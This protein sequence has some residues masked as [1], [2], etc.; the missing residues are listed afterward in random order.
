MRL[1]LIVA[2]ILAFFLP[3]GL[4]AQPAPHESLSGREIGPYRA[5]RTT[6][7]AG[8]PGNGRVFFIGTVGGGVWRTMDAGRSWE[9]ISDGTFGTASVGAIAIAPSDARRM[10]VGMGES[11]YR[12][13]MSSYGDGIY[14]SDDGGDS[15]RKMGLP[16]VRQIAS[17]AIHSR[18]P[19]IV[20]VAAQGDPWSPT[21]ERGVFLSTDGGTTWTRSLFTGTSA[22][23]AE[24]MFDPAD[25]QTVYAS[26][27][28]HDYDPWFLRSG[29]A[30]SGIF[31]STDSGKSWTRLTNGLPSVSG[32]IG[33]A[34][35]PVD[36]KLL[37]AVIETDLEKSGLYRSEDAGAS[38]Q[39]VNRDRRLHTRSWY[40]M[41]V[42]AD[43][44]SRDGVYSMSNPPTRSTD[45]GKTFS[46][47]EANGWDF[48]AIWLDPK[49]KDVMIVGSDGGGT[50]SVDG[51]KTWSSLSNQPTAQLYRVSVDNAY[52]YNIYAAQQDNTTLM[53]SSDRL[54]GGPNSG[55]YQSVGGG[56]AG[57]ISTHP[58]QNRYVYA[59]S[60]LG[61]L[62]EYDR[63]TGAIRYM[64]ATLRFPEGTQ[65]RDLDI[66]YAVNSPV[67]V[68]WA[69]PN[70][71]Y[72]A[73][74]KVMRTR[75]RGQNWEAI[76]P[77]LTRND[78][79]KQGSGG[80]PFS[81]ELIN[82]FGAVAFLAQS[83][84][85]P[86]ILW[87]G[88][89]DGTVS[90]TRDA[91]SWRQVSP[92]GIADAM[93][94]TIDASPHADGRATIAVHRKRL[95]DYRPYIF[96][97]DDFGATWRMI[98]GNLPDDTIVRSVRE[99]KVRKGLLFA[100][101]ER[102]LFVSYDNGG[103]WSLAK[104]VPITPVTGI[105][106]PGDDIVVSTQGRG[107]WGLDGI[108]SLRAWRGSA[109]LQVVPPTVAVLRY[110][111]GGSREASSELV[112]RSD[113]P[114]GAAIDIMLP[115][116]GMAKIEILDQGSR[117]FRTLELTDGKPGLNRV[118]WNL[119]SDPIVLVTGA[120]DGRLD[121]RRARPGVYTVRLSAGSKQ[122]QQQLVVRLDPRLT[123]DEG[124][125]AERRA[126]IADLDRLH[127]RMQ[128]TVVAVREA[129]KR[130]ATLKQAAYD[131]EEMIH[132][133]KMQ[134]VSQD[135]VNFGG[136]LLFDLLV[137]EEILE[138]TPPPYGPNYRQQLDALLAR[139]TAI[140]V[141]SKAITDAAG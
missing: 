92:E 115:T 29:G 122:V 109:A 121:G 119:R 99:D 32:K 11:P 90:V 94:D 105:A 59:S 61:W 118:F 86:E 50:V 135:R 91:A 106:A 7:V 63:E 103:R 116:A 124:Q 44:L 25:P 41:H 36:P 123:I 128:V 102:G 79:S 58:T 14:R 53:I 46:M 113:R 28:D 72:H 71:V 85:R 3:S 48:H 1:S 21:E 141:Q 38:W 140:E 34:I 62:T 27:W 111:G 127:E 18:N 6:A 39:L 37:W 96:Q 5:G 57:F 8:I 134:E 125:M 138:G 52:P 17:I 82:H 12:L 35:S 47:F 136:R 23:A 112:T 54:A 4:I 22:G 131:W 68:S 65:P 67:L 100:G 130:N 15:W 87:T 2:L 66:R 60:E 40:Y 33:L 117:V 104:G 120:F 10:Y 13:Y 20:M 51:G 93:V 81:G 80:G 101:T 56:E 84:R 107:L 55:G 88:S 132:P 95:G 114:E 76:S 64:S 43:P 42:F 16:K 9:N 129:A 108:G 98:A 133:S 19:D 26:T 75:D 83:P 30:G 69:D 137:Y 77:D 70:T 89:N 24:V 74:N 78:K 31:K 97:T 45:G 110:G 49:N 139:W 73:G 126:L